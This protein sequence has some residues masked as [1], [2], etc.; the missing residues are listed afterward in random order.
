MMIG[1]RVLQCCVTRLVVDSPA[2]SA[3]DH[4]SPS[5]WGGKGNGAPFLLSATGTHFAFRF[6]L[7]GFAFF[8]TDRFSLKIFRKAPFVTRT[9]GGLRG[10]RSRG[11]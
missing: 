10:P 11:L 3:R 6:V 9:R 4:P 8:S 2:A 5:S 7:F 1:A